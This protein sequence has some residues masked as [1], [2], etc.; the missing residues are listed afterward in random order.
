MD[1]FYILSS[2]LLIFIGII[3][4]FL[5]PFGLIF[6]MLIMLVFGIARLITNKKLKEQV[7]EWTL[8]LFLT[9]FWIVHLISEGAPTISSYPCGRDQGVIGGCQ[10]MSSAGFPFHGM[11][12]F[13]AGD[14]PYVEM[15]PLFFLNAIIFA[16]LAMFI[17]R[18]L[19]K[20]L[21]EQKIL[22]RM[23][24]IIGIVL[25]LIGQGIIVLRFD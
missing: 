18:F 23:I 3:H 4:T 25:L 6:V 9:V 22:R 2:P 7:S 1:P 16:V 11:H 15:W 5:T 21:L 12:Y 19:P 20:N 24:L 10:V 14:T 8:A 13:P 17:A